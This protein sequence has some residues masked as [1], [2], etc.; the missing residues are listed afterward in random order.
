M[1]VPF[2][3]SFE[4]QFYTKFRLFLVNCRQL[5]GVVSHR[6]GD[7]PVFLEFDRVGF[8][9]LND[10]G[11]GIIGGVVQQVCVDQGSDVVLS[12]FLPSLDNL[13]VADSSVCGWGGLGDDGP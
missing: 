11:S 7:G 1:Q 2:F 6:P 8:A 4:S 3:S 13:H 9:S 5:P 10:L 12:S